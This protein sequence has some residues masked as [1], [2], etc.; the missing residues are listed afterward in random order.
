MK[1]PAAWRLLLLT[2]G[3]LLGLL[4]GLVVAPATAADFHST[5]ATQRL[6]LT[7]ATSGRYTVEGRNYKGEVVDVWV[8]KVSGRDSNIAS[9][10]VR[11]GTDDAFTF[12]GWGLRC[13]ETYQAVS[14]SP[15]DGW[16][17]SARKRLG[18]R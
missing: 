1:K 17:K 13:D 5:A 4:A 2:A 15:E 16:D 9:K 6:A 7:L 8:V 12:R 14:Y 11:P 10:R 18:C 3:A